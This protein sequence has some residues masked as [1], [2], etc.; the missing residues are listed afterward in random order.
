MFCRIL[1]SGVNIGQFSCYRY[2]YIHLKGH[3]LTITRVLAC[4]EGGVDR[5]GWGAQFGVGVTFGFGWGLFPESRAAS[6]ILAASHR[7]QRLRAYGETGSARCRK[8]VLRSR[9]CHE[10]HTEVFTHVSSSICHPGHLLTHPVETN[11]MWGTRNISDFWS[12]FTQDNFRLR[13]IWW[14]QWSMKH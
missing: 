14:P 13:E 6:L 7:V 3:L 2:E 10:A 9:H 1:T 5:F 4:G 8:P 11:S 12:I